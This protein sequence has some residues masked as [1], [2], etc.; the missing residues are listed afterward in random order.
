MILKKYNLI[1]VCK[2]CLSHD[3]VIVWWELLV[4]MTMSF[5]FSVGF[6]RSL[7]WD[8]TTPGVTSYG[9]STLRMR[10]GRLRPLAPP[11][12]TQ[13]HMSPLRKCQ[14]RRQRM[15][16][17]L[18]QEVAIA[19]S[20]MPRITK[21]SYLAAAAVKT[22]ILTW[23]TFGHTISGRNSGKNYYHKKSWSRKQNARQWNKH[24]KWV[25]W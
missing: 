5:M 2:M 13:M 12:L 18:A 25:Q 21:L 4:N 3:M 15:K 8:A 23:T 9:S 19:W 24:S 10:C 6:C 7:G 14:R 20:T 1:I 11:A 22:P 16:P 17:C